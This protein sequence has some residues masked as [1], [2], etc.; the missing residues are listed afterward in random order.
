MRKAIHAAVLV[1][2]LL[3]PFTILGQGAPPGGTVNIVGGRMAT[4]FGFPW[5]DGTLVFQGK[6]HRFQID[7]FNAQDPGAMEI[8]A[9]GEVT[10][11]ATLNDFAGPYAATTSP[12]AA[13]IMQIT[14]KNAHGVVLQIHA[15]EGD[16]KPTPGPAGISVTLKN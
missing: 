14:L 3:S 6:T 4:G 8:T 5:G 9:T 1:T 2:G 13:G 12:P 16:L 11:L 10:N 15:K 7:G